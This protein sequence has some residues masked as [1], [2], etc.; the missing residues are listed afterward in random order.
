VAG[1]IKAED[2]TAVK[3]RTSIEDVVRDHVT[4]RPAGVGSLKGLCPFHD[5]KS[6]SFTVRPAV[7]SYH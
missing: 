5:E 3:E 4:L 1:R 2:I 6:P 7:G